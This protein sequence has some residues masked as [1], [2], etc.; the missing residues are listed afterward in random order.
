MAAVRLNERRVEALKPYKSTYDVR[1]RE[2]KAFGVR[3]PASGA[4]RYFIHTQYNGRRVWKIVGHVGSIGADEAPGRS[5]TLLAAIQKGNDD[6][7]PPDTPFE[8]A[9]DEVFRRYAHVG[10]RNTEAAAER[11]GAAI[12]LALGG[13]GISLDN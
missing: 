8:T 4:K 11:I 7:A 6:V 10:D 5:K 2:L 13:V 3:I 1:D 12:A 9:A